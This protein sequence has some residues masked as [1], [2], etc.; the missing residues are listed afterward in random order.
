MTRWSQN[1]SFA[2]PTAR[3]TSRRTISRCL[4]SSSET[5]PEH[6][7][8][9]EILL[10]RP[11]EWST[12]A[13]DELQK[14]LIA[15]PQRFTTEHL[16]RAHKLRYD[17]ALADVISMVKHAADKKVPLLTAEERVDAA[18]QRF[19]KDKDLSDEQLEWLKRIRTHL[20]QNLSIDKHDFNVVPI[21]TL[22]GGWGPANRTFDGKL[23]PMLDELNE[24]V[25]A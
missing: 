19:S 20:V 17:V 11:K 7:G 3:S 25:A 22:N 24:A 4:R 13:L 23:S 1:G 5:N 16:Q 10:D 18:V 15:A 8:A 2:E 21:F 6:I 14:K 12:D 9:I